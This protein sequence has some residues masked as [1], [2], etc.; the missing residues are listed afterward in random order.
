MQGIKLTYGIELKILGLKLI[1][2]KSTPAGH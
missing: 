1:S 2:R